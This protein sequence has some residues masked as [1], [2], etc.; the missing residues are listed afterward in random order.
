[1][2]AYTDAEKARFWE[3][4]Q[5]REKFYDGRFFYGV[6]TTGIYCNPSCPS[7][8]PGLPSVV[9]FETRGDADKAGFRPCKR[10]RPEVDQT[11]EA[12]AALFQ[13]A[14]LLLEQ[15]MDTVTTV[16]SWADTTNVSLIH[17]RRIVKE[18]SGLSPR[19]FLMNRKVE[20]FKQG[21]QSG[22]NVTT[23]LYSAGF[24][25]SSRL[26]EKASHRLGMTPGKYKNG[27]NGERIVF[28][29]IE[30]PYG[31]LL[32]AATRNGVCSVKFGSVGTDLTEMLREEFPR[33]EIAVDTG[34]L[35]S[36]VSMI[37][38][39]FDGYSG[40]L[41]IPLDLQASAFRHR[42]WEELR[43]IPFGE[44][45]SYSQ[46]AEAIGQPTAVR[47]VASACAANPVAL[48]T[49]C[50]RVIHSD[51]SISGY[52]WGFERK[53]ALL[54]AERKNAAKTIGK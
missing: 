16:Q 21:V 52:R 3:A 30:T 28:T 46:V 22:E 14:I 23:A 12:D 41:D 36:W 32:V 53:Q 2:T 31:D 10:C 1:M 18:V 50:H 40:S 43:R 48:V 42:V 24:G 13:R 6:K 7:K 29:I 45:R 37:Q 44:T 5:N 34:E 27:G 38:N 39:Y 26:Y 8:K 54:E 35:S 11:V 9:F 51:G 15:H 17:L 4:V 49:P 25:S 19:E 20:A 47:A 33:A